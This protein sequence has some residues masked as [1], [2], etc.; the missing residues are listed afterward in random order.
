MFY[1]RGSICLSICSH[2]AGIAQHYAARQA[3]FAPNETVSFLQIKMP[4]H[5]CG[6]QIACLGDITLAG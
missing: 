1:S 2:F 6:V 5:G 4:Y 3:R